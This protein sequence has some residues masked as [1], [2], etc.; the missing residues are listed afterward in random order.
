MKMIQVMLVG[1]RQTPN[2]I[3]VMKFSPNQIVL[4]VSKDERKQK[5]I[6][7]DSLRSIKSLNPP[8]D[9]DIIEV[10]AYDFPANLVAIRGVCN[11]YHN[12]QIQFNLTGSTKIMA[13]AGY[14]IAREKE[15]ASFYVAGNRIL[16]LTGQ[17]HQAIEKIDLNIKQYLKIFGRDISHKFKFDSLSFDKLCAINAAKLLAINTTHSANMLKKI[18]KNANKTKDGLQVPLGD[19]GEDEKRIAMNLKDEGALDVDGDLIRI[20]SNNDLEFFKGNWLEV[21]VYNEALNK[22]DG[23]GAPIFDY[24][25]IS[26][27][28]K[29]DQAEKEIDVACIHEAQLIHCSCKTD[30]DP[31]KTAYLDELHSISNMIGGRF[32]S[33][34]FVTNAVF[35]DKTKQSQFLDQAKEREIV[36]VTGNELANIGKILF[37]QAK[38]PEFRRV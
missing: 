34:V 18:R 25:D 35:P 32:C 13:L 22:K 23:A 38:K 19:F 28:I 33:R 15:I 16:W 20:R 8:D 21:F 11:K 6:L 37:K 14:E 30:G 29:S 10:D 2:V 3:G 26:L 17:E 31:F 36:V 9:E 7:L 4:I 1:G 24:C 27:E 12:K 5:D